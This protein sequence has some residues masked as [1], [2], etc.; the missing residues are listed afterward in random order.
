MTDKKFRRLSRSELV[1]IIYELQKNE[2]ELKKQK[3]ALEKE[4]KKLKN[5]LELRELKLSQAGSIAEATV[6]LSGIFEAAQ[7]AAD[8]YLSQI[9]ADNADVESRCQKILSDAEDE[10]ERIIRNADE[11]VEEKWTEFRKKTDEFM[12]A[13]NELKMFLKD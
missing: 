1:E 4:N 11:Q 6:E 7:N 13:H 9:K 8:E 10:A 2:Q 12:R 5:S 3:S